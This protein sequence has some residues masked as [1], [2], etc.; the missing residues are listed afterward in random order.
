VGT[1]DIEKWCRRFLVMQLLEEKVVTTKKVADN[2]T[3]VWVNK[4]ATE[5]DCITRSIDMVKH[6]EPLFL[7]INTRNSQIQ[8]RCLVSS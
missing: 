5:E 6:W 4:L 2:D 1:K 7:N 3:T 8:H